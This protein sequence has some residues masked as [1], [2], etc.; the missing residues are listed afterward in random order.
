MN[1]KKSPN[2]IPQHRRHGQNKGGIKTGG[3]GKKAKSS[4]WKEVK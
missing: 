1:K 4:N 2:K 3:R